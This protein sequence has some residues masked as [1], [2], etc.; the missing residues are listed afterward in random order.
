[1]RIFIILICAIITSIPT[2]VISSPAQTKQTIKAHPAMDLEKAKGLVSDLSIKFIDLL[3][4]RDLSGNTNTE[5]QKNDDF[6]REAKDIYTQ[7]FDEEKIAVFIL[8]KVW[9][10]MSPDQKTRFLTLLPKRLSK[11]LRE[12]LHSLD[13]QKN[14]AVQ[15]GELKITRAY[16]SNPDRGNISVS[17]TMLLRTRTVD[18]YDKEKHLEVIW[19]LLPNGRVYDVTVEGISA[20]KLFQNEFRSSLSETTIDTFLENLAASVNR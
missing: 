14:S 12:L 2:C 17:S 9:D 1:M 7:Y 4:K 16:V 19:A 18:G 15:G 11:K 6:Y 8:G 5:Q 10:N 20:I 13:D 3:K